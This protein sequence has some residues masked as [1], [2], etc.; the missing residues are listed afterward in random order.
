MNDYFE[1]KGFSEL[2]QSIPLSDSN[3]ASAWM[4]KLSF[5][6]NL[7]DQ[8]FLAYMKRGASIFNSNDVPDLNFTSKDANDLPAMAWYLKGVSGQQLFKEP[9]GFI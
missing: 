4:M 1:S 6:R 8:Q 3:L 5:N 9:L 7:T 2:Q